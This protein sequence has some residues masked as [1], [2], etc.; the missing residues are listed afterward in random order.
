MN[1]KVAI[2]TVSE[3]F[4]N[5]KSINHSVVDILSLQCYCVLST[6]AQVLRK[7]EFKTLSILIFDALFITDILIIPEG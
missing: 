5:V 3:K 7:N 2:F 4:I 6:I 1:V